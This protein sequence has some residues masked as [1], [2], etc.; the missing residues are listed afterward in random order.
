MIVLF[1]V[2]MSKKLLHNLIL[3]SFNQLPALPPLLR[4]LLPLLQQLLLWLEQKRLHPHPLLLAT[5][6][7]RCREDAAVASREHAAATRRRPDEEHDLYYLESSCVRRRVV[8]ASSSKPSTI[9]LGLCTGVR[10][11][12]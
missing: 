4:L 11:Q 10:Y 9:I 8:F 1:T 7:L 5:M 3:S 6:V 2:H 12:W